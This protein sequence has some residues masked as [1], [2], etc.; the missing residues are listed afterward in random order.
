MTPDIQQGRDGYPRP[1]LPRRDADAAVHPAARAAEAPRAGRWDAAA[2][3][4][5]VFQ[6]VQAPA[7]APRQA[8]PAASGT[9]AERAREDRSIVG[10][11]PYLAVLVCAV[12]GVYIAWREGSAGGGNGAAVLGAALLAAAVARLL[13]PARLVGLLAARKRATDVLT[14]TVFGVGLLV[15]GLVLPR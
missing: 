2:A 3:P 11:V 13:L 7:E 1:Q 6:P 12:V 8:A 15:A 4:A 9:E 5:R 14:L 10:V